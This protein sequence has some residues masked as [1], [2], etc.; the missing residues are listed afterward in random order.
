[1]VVKPKTVKA[2][3][4]KVTLEGRVVFDWTFGPLHEV[5][6]EKAEPSDVTPDTLNLTAY[7]MVNE[8]CKEDHVLSEQMGKLLLANRL[9]M[10][11]GGLEDEETEVDR[12]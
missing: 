7:S 8:R 10:A 11:V 1:M 9:R 3:R 4:V 2:T 12:G 5:T 6:L